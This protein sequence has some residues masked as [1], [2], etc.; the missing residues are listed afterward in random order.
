MSENNH[1]NGPDNE[2][3]NGLSEEDIS[4]YEEYIS[5]HTASQAA[6]DPEPG[7]KEMAEKFEGQR[8][9][10]NQGEELDLTAMDPTLRRVVVALGWDV[11][12]YETPEPDLDASVFLLKNDEQTRED[13][14]FIFYN[15]MSGCD[16]AVEHQG[17]NRTGAGDGDDETVV[18]DL[19]GIPFDIGK[20]EFVVSI[21]DAHDRGHSF[22][23]VRNVFLRI[24]NKDT[25]QELVIYYLD[26]NI[27]GEGSEALKV[28]HLQREGPNWLF[29][30][31]S[32][33]VKGGLAK[34]ATDYGIIVAEHTSTGG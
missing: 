16:G 18:I 10:I 4:G 34:I 28:G 31:K 20:L 21:Y 24:V 13:S 14:D 11:I 17:D 33:G 3:D 25:N 15:N 6:D 23:N 22:D 19:N 12:G 29:V 27:A 7:T 2:Q 9:T 1:T 26:N 5:D 32:E 30:A 8:K